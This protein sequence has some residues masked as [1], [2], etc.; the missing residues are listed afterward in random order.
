MVNAPVLSSRY[1]HTLVRVQIH[2]L[3]N[4]YTARMVCF[5]LAQRRQVPPPNLP[6]QDQTQHD[7]GEGQEHR[8]AQVHMLRKGCEQAVDDLSQGNFPQPGHS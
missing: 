3:P 4:G 2:D 8:H 1:F 7:A 5:T 6:S